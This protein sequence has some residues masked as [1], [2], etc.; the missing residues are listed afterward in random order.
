MAINLG[1]FGNTAVQRPQMQPMVQ[2]PSTGAA[3]VAIGQML[4]NV[5]QAMEQ[6]KAELNKARGGT[7]MADLQVATHAL[8]ADL[9]D[10]VSRGEVKPEEMVTTYQKEA[11]ALKSRMLLD[12]DPSLVE[13]VSGPADNYLK[14]SEIPVFDMSKVRIRDGYEAEMAKSRSSLEAG[15]ISN[16]AASVASIN[17]IYDTIG[18]KAG[19]DQTKIEAAKQ[20]DTQKFYMANRMNWAGQNESMGELKQEEAKLSDDTY[21]TQLG[22][23][24]VRYRDYVQTRIRELKSAKEARTRD[25]EVKVQ[26]DLK[27]YSELLSEGRE[28]PPGVRD[29]MAQFQQSIKGTKYGRMFSEMVKENADTRTLAMAPI[30]EQAAMIEKKR[31]QSIEAADNP[32]RAVEL[33]NQAERMERIASRNIKAIQE[34]PYRYAK[35]VHGIEVAPLD[36]SQDLS[37]Q[38]LARDKQRAQIQAR[39]GVNAGLLSPDEASQLAP[40]MDTLPAATQEQ[41]FRSIAGVDPSTQRATLAQIGKVDPAKMYAGAHTVARHT[42]TVNGVKGRSVGRML[43]EGG[44]IVSKKQIQMEPKT[45]IAINAQVAAYAGEALA[46]DPDEFAAVAPMVTA[47]LAFQQK[48]RGNLEMKPS[49]EDIQQAVDIVTGGIVTFNEGQ[50]ILPY[51]MKAGDF[52]EKAPLA[53]SLKLGEAGYNDQQ[54]N[55]MIDTATLRPSENADEYFIFNGRD[56]VP[57]RDG[58]PL[59]VRVR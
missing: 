12:K 36:F 28:I 32:E 56:P 14:G 33:K 35:N 52:K 26:S 50:T 16:P 6:E 8:G 18:P 22:D 23:Q 47:F 20:T 59:R 57:G 17:Q 34:D 1:N 3:V 46:H 27:L 13:L 43:I 30:T 44:Q 54:R 58:Q 4:G 21:L 40:M 29:D 2:Q 7:F 24:R 41:V 53:I 38:L 25:W 11:A 49:K 39:T 51:G 31:R 42:A 55:R 15:A 10:R 48:D 5:H 9:N 45:L 19:W 37:A